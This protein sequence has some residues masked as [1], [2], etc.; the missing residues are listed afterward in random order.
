MRGVILALLLTDSSLFSLLSS[1][2]RGECQQQGGV[3]EQ[4]AG[5]KYR[6]T[7]AYL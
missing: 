7:D 3:Q 2:K 6:G 4:T 5:S 1:A